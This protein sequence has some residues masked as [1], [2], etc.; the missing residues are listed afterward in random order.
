[1]RFH[2]DPRVHLSTPRA[3]VSCLEDIACEWSYVDA[4]QHRCIPQLVSDFMSYS[5][6][7]IAIHTSRPNLRNIHGRHVTQSTDRTVFATDDNK[8]YITLRLARFAIVDNTVQ[9]DR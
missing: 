1:M 7:Q 9:A 6:T 4:S 5:E 8:N 2:W 3:V